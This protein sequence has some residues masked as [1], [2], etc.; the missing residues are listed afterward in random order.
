MIWKDLACPLWNTFLK[1]G[2]LQGSVAYL[3]LLY[4]S[5]HKWDLSSV[6]LWS[7]LSQLLASEYSCHLTI[8]RWL[9]KMYFWRQHLKLNCKWKLNQVA[10]VLYTSSFFLEMMEHITPFVTTSATWTFM[11][12]C[13]LSFTIF[14]H[15]Q[16]F[17][18][19]FFIRS[20]ICDNGYYETAYLNTFP[21]TH[22]LH[23]DLVHRLKRCKKK[24]TPFL[25]IPSTSCVEIITLALKFLFDWIYCIP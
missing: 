21:I 22:F 5:I 9:K 15:A 6:F 12:F 19:Q 23:A 16:K 1:D 24:N 2:L 20:K 11:S 25:Y 14:L 13:W 17:V 4:K 3:R 18:K 8:G 10:D 7:R